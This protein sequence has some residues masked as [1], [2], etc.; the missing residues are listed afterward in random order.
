MWA[1]LPFI[2]ANMRENGKYIE[3]MYNGIVGLHMEK[4]ILG[5]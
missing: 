1:Y 4:I 5:I 2:F 3:A